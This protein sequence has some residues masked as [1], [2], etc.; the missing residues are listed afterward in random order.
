MPTSAPSPNVLPDPWLPCPLAEVER[1]LS[2]PDDGV[3]DTLRATPGDILVL[4]AGGKMGLHLCLMLR[5]A[6][7]E[8]GRDHSV[9]AVS[10]F[11]T[12]HSTAD[13]REHEIATQTCDLADPQQLAAL[14]DWPLVFFLAG[15]KFGT[16]SNPELLQR[17]NVEVPQLVAERYRRARIVALSTGC[18]YSYVGPQTG[19][20]VES[21]ATGPVG[22]YARSCLGRE[23]AFAAGA[24]RHGTPVALV[25]LNY[26]VEFR[27]GV[28][29]DICSRVLRGEPVSVAMGY[30]NVIWQRDA[31]AEIIRTLPLTTPQPFVLNI[32]GDAVLSVRQLAHEFGRLLDRPVQIEGAEEPTAWLS[33]SAQAQRLFGPPA[34]CLA[35]MLRWTAAW[36]R[37]GGANYHKPT[38]F[39][40]RD[41]KF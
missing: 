22:D 38:G 25:R 33:N 5:R 20:S 15:A 21:D 39:E 36:V 29:A 30:V 17:M 37:S 14:P 2:E 11:T 6:L 18:V 12:L 8:L 1:F 35:D 31:I 40:K 19:G 28:L 13:F 23:Q 10:R 41:G 26:S 3:L 16:A 9:L 27:Y 34:T 32:T 24:Q 4:G 7:A